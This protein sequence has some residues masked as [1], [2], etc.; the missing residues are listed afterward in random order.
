MIL[1]SL[2]AG[3]SA[4]ES[5]AHLTLGAGTPWAAHFIVP[6]PPASTVHLLRLDDEGRVDVD[7]DVGLVR[8][9]RAEP[10]GHHALVFA[11]IFVIH[12]LQNEART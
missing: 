4:P 10:V 2:A 7:S 6:D 3:K 5:L 9:G 11:G 1:L 12:V 8:I